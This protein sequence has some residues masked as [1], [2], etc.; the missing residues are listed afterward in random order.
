[1]GRGRKGFRRSRSRASGLDL[2]GAA[3]GLPLFRKAQRA[4]K[5]VPQITIDY[6]SD[7]EGE[8]YA[9]ESTTEQSIL[10]DDDD[11]DDADTISETRPYVSAPRTRATRSRTPSTV[12]R[13]QR[14]KPSTASTSRRSSHRRH[15]R[16]TSRRRS[17]TPAALTATAASFV[18]PSA[19]YPS[20][21]PVHLSSKPFCMT[22]PTPSFSDSALRPP[23]ATVPVQPQQQQPMYYQPQFAIVP[24]PASA[25][26]PQYVASSL[27][28]PAFGCPQ[29]IPQSQQATMEA[30]NQTP[31]R[32]STDWTDDSG[33]YARELVRLQRKV[34][35][36]MKA[37]A[38]QP[39]NHGLR[40]DLRKLQNQL[41]KTM[42]AAI[43]TDRAPKE[44]SETEH[45]PKVSLKSEVSQ[46]KLS[47]AVGDIPPVQGAQ[48]SRED[49]NEP[50]PIKQETEE[51]RD[52]KAM[53]QRDETPIAIPNRHICSACGCVRSVEFHDK[54]PFDPEVKPVFNF[55]EVCLARKI[56]RGLVGQHHFCFCCGQARSRS[57]HDQHSILPGDPILPNYCTQCLREMRADERITDESVLGMNSDSDNNE[58][59]KKEKKKNKKKKSRMPAVEE[60]EDCDSL[61]THLHANSRSERGRS[62]CS[63]PTTSSTEE[64]SPYDLSYDESTDPKEHGPCS[65]THHRSLETLNVPKRTSRRPAV[66][67]PEPSY[68]PTRS[69]GSSERRAQRKSSSQF[70]E[71]PCACSTKT[72]ASR[73]YQAPYVEDA[74][75]RRGTPSP[76]VPSTS[77]RR[78]G[79]ASS[80]TDNNHRDS[81]STAKRVDKGPPPSASSGMANSLKSSSSGDSSGGSKTVRFKQSVDIRTPLSPTVK[82]EPSPIDNYRMDKERDDDAGPSRT[83]SSPLVPDHGNPASARFR[84]E[85]RPASH[86]LDPDYGR[87]ASNHPDFYH[88]SFREP[89]S[90]PR[91]TPSPG[92]SQGAFGKSFGSASREWDGFSSY[93]ESPMDRN[94]FGAP[95]GH[96]SARMSGFTGGGKSP[97]SP[98]AQDFTETP[99]SQ[100]SFRAS[101]FGSFFNKNSQG[102]A[103]APG[104]DERADP[105]PP[106]AS[107]PDREESSS[108]DDRSFYSRQPYSG[109]YTAFTDPEYY[110]FGEEDESYFQ[111]DSYAQDS[112]PYYTPRQRHG[113]G[114]FS[115]PDFGQA[116][117]RAAHFWGSKRTRAHWPRTDD[118]IPE[119]IIEEVSSVGPPSPAQS[120][121]LIE[122]NVLTDSSCE[123]VS[124]DDSE[125]EEVTSDDDLGESI[126]MKPKQLLLKS[127]ADFE[128]GQDL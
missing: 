2:L 19:T 102:S 20:H 60:E 52:K 122:Y 87:F 35:R 59:K 71:E 126:I 1:M 128:K 25:Q 120:I 88:G 101:G 13:H 6:D 105:S 78:K 127:A 34:E 56:K 82:D 108:P 84:D 116:R 98:Y 9:E 97:R 7:S 29:P 55:C 31:D 44:E 30:A 68:H 121:K 72:Q 61:R 112:N 40:A 50:P 83:W 8:S 114:Y 51:D 100:T 79:K 69:H 22:Q 45:A 49:G 12:R 47:D 86:Y 96:P 62:R 125:T 99:K 65:R 85:R 70:D 104:G 118:P 10:S 94:G 117:E 110:Y 111:S 28:Q 124:S 93:E 80:V 37:L 91:S 53:G 5:K 36:K 33:P 21:V 95:F 39:H 27:A 58:K 57:F 81:G 48:P 77:S 76:T 107:S 89:G 90:V 14:R 115:E 113:H 3:F 24:A 103:K 74:T 38:Q 11:D 54:H 64:E 4:Q 106:M 63:R 67:S 18:R 46:A 109:T 123:S 23:F 42:N 16:P 15:R 73:E 92:F 17:S 75:S 41:N 26:V 43:A 32:A 66:D 119:P